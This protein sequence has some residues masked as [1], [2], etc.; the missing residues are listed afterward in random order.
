[1]PSWWFVILSFLSLSFIRLARSVLRSITGRRSVIILIA[2][3]VFI[4]LSSGKGEEN[5]FQIR[6]ADW[7][8][9][10]LQRVLC[11]LNGAKYLAALHLSDVSVLNSVVQQVVVPCLQTAIAAEAVAH[12]ALN[13]I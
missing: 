9:L 5:L 8:V 3:A 13:G 6:L 10:N 7:V 11:P 4:T 1:M 12:E 2:F